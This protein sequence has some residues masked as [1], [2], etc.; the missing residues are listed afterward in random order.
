[1]NKV[2]IS[3]IS[4]IESFI[5]VLWNEIKNNK[6]VLFNG[7]MGV[8]KTTLVSYLLKYVGVN[9]SISS[10]TYS[11][12]NE[13]HN[14]SGEIYYHFDFYRIKNLDEA[15]DIGTEDYFYSGHTCFIEWPK[16]IEQLIPDNFISVN[17]ETE[18]NI[19]YI[20]VSNPNLE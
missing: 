9:D 12:V 20:S 18:G 15:M 14:N 16:K 13:Y 7:D 5:P 10:P 17:I 3:T 1:M 11:I 2:K 8:G 19:R 4:E 6:I